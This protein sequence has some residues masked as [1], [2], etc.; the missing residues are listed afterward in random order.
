[1]ANTLRAV[2]LVSAVSR[3]SCRCP[4]HAL[5]LPGSRDTHHSHH[6]SQPSTDYAF[7]MACS[8]IRY[9][10]G[11]TKEV[12]MDMKNFGATNVCLMVDPNLVNLPPV[13][14]TLNSLH[15][16]NVQY[17]MFS[18]ISIEPT[19]ESFRKAI[20]F[21]RKDKFDAFLA[22]GGGSTMDTCKAANLYSSNPHRE[23]LDF[24]NAPIGKGIPIPSNLKP[25]VAVPTTAGTG[26][27]TTGVAIFDYMPLRA[28][29]GIAHRALRPT[30]G[31]VD[32]LHSLHMPE[33][34][35]AYSGFDVLCHALE[36]YTAIPYHKRSPCPSN[37]I[38]RP[39]YQGSNPISDVWSLYALKIIR[40]YFK[41]SVYDNTDVEARSHMHLASV[42]AGIGFGNAG[43]HLC[44]GM[45]YPI[46]GQVKTYSAEQYITDHPII[47]HG[48]SV[49]MTSPAV[50]SFTS[51][52]CP[53]RHI[54]AVDA[55][56]GDTTNLKREDAGRA[57]ADVLREYMLNMKVDNGLSAL[58]YS[59]SDIPSLVKGTLPQHRVTKLSPRP[60]TEEDL[61]KLFEAS[62]TVY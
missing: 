40:K 62:M 7:E 35:A 1:M 42:Y 13:K 24:V 30:L 48:L 45:S 9:G 61:S 3:A 57:L 26:S 11:V 17:S 18:G 38:E 12:G 5:C 2:N 10:P 54:E 36:S 31:I 60:Q 15:K 41:R 22:V 34:V 33:R 23:F 29:T 4:A 46:A 8:N 6:E 37:P 50:F 20:D 53:E 32:P 14:E 25:L 39:A 19:D 16:H 51:P 27:E 43:V 49:V 59:V 21:A 52:M 58:G 55:L 56:G 44:H 47:P 28:K